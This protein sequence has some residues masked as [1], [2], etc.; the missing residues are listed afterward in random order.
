MLLNRMDRALVAYDTTIGVAVLLFMQLSTV[1]LPE[2]DT[3]KFITVVMLPADATQVQTFDIV[4]Q[5]G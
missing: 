5:A 1:F 3:G 2:G 4:W